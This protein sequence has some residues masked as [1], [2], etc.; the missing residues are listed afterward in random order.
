M[1]DKIAAGRLLPLFCPA[2]V[3][4][5]REFEG[6]SARAEVGDAGDARGE[7]RLHLVGELVATAF[8]G[9]GKL[10]PECPSRERK[11]GRG[12]VDEKDESPAVIEIKLMLG[13]GWCEKPFWGQGK[14]TDGERGGALSLCA[15][16]RAWIFE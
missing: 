10:L 9:F 13:S 5:C 6:V 2:T 16:P 3:D 8:P 15:Q 11:A 12:T 14:R 4:V 7:G 1:P